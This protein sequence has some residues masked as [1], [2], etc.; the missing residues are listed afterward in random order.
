MYRAQCIHRCMAAGL[1]E[2]PQH[3]RAESIQVCEIID[4]INQQCSEIGF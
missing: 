2:F 3:T 4:E 1:T